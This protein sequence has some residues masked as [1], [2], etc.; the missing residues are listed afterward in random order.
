VLLTLS[1]CG[2]HR[3]IAMA[4]LDFKRTWKKSSVLVRRKMLHMRDQRVGGR[5]R[6]AATSPTE[7]AEV[8]PL[9]VPQ[10]GAIPQG[11]R[12]LGGAG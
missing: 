4:A 3:A 2:C 10:E 7:V 8:L 12:Q 9:D 5:R 6:G 11:S 1:S